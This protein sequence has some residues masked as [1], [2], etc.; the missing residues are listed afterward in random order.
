MQ[1][2]HMSLESGHSDWRQKQGQGLHMLTQEAS[3][4]VP[5]VH[6]AATGLWQDYLP[7]ALPLDSPCQRFQQGLQLTGQL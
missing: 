1:A 3:L 6:P 5:N 7:Y 4:F 2:L